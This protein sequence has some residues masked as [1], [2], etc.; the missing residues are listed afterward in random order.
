MRVIK[1]GMQN[2]YR[3]FWLSGA[4]IIILI[5]MFLSLSSLVSLN[6]LVRQT[7]DAV[8]EKV[9]LSLYLK[10]EISQNYLNELITDLENLSQVQSI[11]T[12]SPQEAY[13]N[14]KE[15]HKDDLEIIKSLEEINHNPFGPTLLIRTKADADINPILELIASPRYQDIILEK[16]L[17][18]YQELINKIDFW[19]RR[20]KFLG[21][22]ISGVFALIVMLVIFNAIRLSIYARLEE[23]KIMRLVG[24]TSWSIR[25]PFLIEIFISVFLASLISLFLFLSI[26]LK[27]QPQI[28]SFLNFQINLFNYLVNNALFIWSGQIAFS[29][30]I[31]WLSASL[32]MKKYLKI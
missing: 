30:L 20:I 31:C 4:I 2:F 25:A 18:N 3:N 13:E 32:A 22:I 1:A 9:D 27:F 28:A 14:F 23:I 26:I 29:L 16:D 11:K 8:R 10:P 17:T 5:L 12:I 19:G 7:V 6:V 15:K 24:A 21:F